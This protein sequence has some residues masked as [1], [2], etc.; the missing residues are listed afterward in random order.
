[1]FAVDSWEGVNGSLTL[2]MLTAAPLAALATALD[3]MVGN[4]T[5][6]SSVDVGM[7]SP[8]STALLS[9]DALG[10]LARVVCSRSLAGDERIGHSGE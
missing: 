9:V 7:F 4:V 2:E 3:A 10:R 8:L 1:L 6:L 5:K